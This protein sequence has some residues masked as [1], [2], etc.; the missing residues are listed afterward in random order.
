LAPHKR[1]PVRRDALSCNPFSRARKFLPFQRSLILGSRHKIKE[2]TKINLIRADPQPTKFV[3][4]RII[5]S[6]QGAQRIIAYR[7]H[8][9][10]SRK[11]NRRLNRLGIAMALN[12]LLRTR[13]M[14]KPLFFL[15][16]SA[17]YGPAAGGI[18]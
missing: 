3:A 15:R 9:S 17:L 1:R 18:E 11:R 4:A 16:I 2:V 10:I 5:G 7:N 6:A 14:P 8:G 12:G 13:K